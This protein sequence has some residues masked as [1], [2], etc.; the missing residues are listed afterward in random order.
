MVAKE[1]LA[2]KI[3]RE[4]YLRT[5]DMTVKTL[6]REANIGSSTTSSLHDSKTG[7]NYQVPTGKIFRLL[8]I[9]MKNETVQTVDFV[10]IREG[11]TLDTADGNIVFDC[12]PMEV[13]RFHNVYCQIDFAADKFVTL[14][15]SGQAN[16][17]HA[18]GIEM[19]A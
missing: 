1:P 10:R 11:N 13:T 9:Q 17:I 7:A 2:I 18:Y 6:R 15:P 3:G 4:T 14:Q 5:S 12:G 19:D 8:L 16:Y